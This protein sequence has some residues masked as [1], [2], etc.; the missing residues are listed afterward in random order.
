RPTPA[1][2]APPASSP[3]CKSRTSWTTSAPPCGGPSTKPPRRLPD[4]GES[5]VTKNGG[6]TVFGNAS[7]FCC[8]PA[9]RRC[10]VKPSGANVVPLREVEPRGAREQHLVGHGRIV[11][12]R[13]IVG[14]RR[15]RGRTGPLLEQGVEELPRQLGLVGTH[16]QG[17]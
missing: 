3:S 16:E 2:C 5:P 4:A 12:A 15:A 6:A 1:P 13:R 14:E 7:V 9:G 17:R 11:R 8:R 10:P